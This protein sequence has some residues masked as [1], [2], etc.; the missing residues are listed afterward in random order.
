M[1]CKNASG[2]GVVEER[3]QHLGTG[4]QFW[5]ALGGLEPVAGRCRNK[6]LNN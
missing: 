3:R 5:A 2:V 4:K 1:G 6:S